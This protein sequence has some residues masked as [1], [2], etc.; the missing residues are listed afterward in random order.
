MTESSLRSAEWRK[1]SEQEMADL[2]DRMLE[3]P[4]TQSLL[5]CFTEAGATLEEAK[6]KYRELNGIRDF[7]AAGE[8]RF[9]MP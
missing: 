4:M 7:T 1:I 9:F 8:C 3:D 6:R 5:E 2:D